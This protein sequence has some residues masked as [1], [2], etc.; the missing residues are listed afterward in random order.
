MFPLSVAFDG[1]DKP[2]RAGFILL[3]F[4]GFVPILLGRRYIGRAAPG[5]MKS[6][7]DPALRLR[8]TFVARIAS[9]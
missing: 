6:C 7:A 8:T 3:G 9:A 4:L 2:A 5:L 1:G